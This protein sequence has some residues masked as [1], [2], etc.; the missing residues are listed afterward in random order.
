MDPLT[1]ATTLAT[2]IGLICNYRQE[3]GNRSALDH[4]KFIEWLEYHRHEQLKNLVVNTV[5]LQNEVS[6]MLKSPALNSN[7]DKQ[8]SEQALSILRQFA[9][10]GAEDFF[11]ENYGGG[12]FTL[13]WD[14]GT[15]IEITELRFLEDDL[16]KLVQV[17]LLLPEQ[18]G[19][20]MLRFRLARNAVKML[21]A[22]EKSV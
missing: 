10:S 20:K 5:A 19:S 3:K 15:E 9:N 7:E 6:N 4:Q 2:L 12:N 1:A 13:G 8:L 18:T 17:G 21:Q 22:I 11:Y 14:A 16:D